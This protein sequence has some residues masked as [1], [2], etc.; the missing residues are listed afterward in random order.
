MEDVSNSI[1]KR[2]LTAKFENL[3][4][5]SFF[6]LIN[7]SFDWM[8]KDEKSE[9]ISEQ[10]LSINFGHFDCIW[11]SLKKLLNF[12]EKLSIIFQLHIILEF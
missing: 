7:K 2:L 1:T 8:R 3:Y 10:S 4:L 11:I 6:F 9:F 12:K 5:I